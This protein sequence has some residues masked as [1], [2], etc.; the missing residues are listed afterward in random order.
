MVETNINAIKYIHSVHEFVNEIKLLDKALEYS[1]HSSESSDFKKGRLFFRGQRNAEWSVCPSVFRNDFLLEESNMYSR[2]LLSSPSDF[3]DSTTTYEKLT[4]MQHYGLPTRLLDVT[5]N[6]LIAL[7]FACEKNENTKE[8]KSIKNLISEKDKSILSPE[9][10]EIVEK[11]LI[12]NETFGEVFV[13]ADDPLEP[14]DDRVKVLA[15]LAHLCKNE[16]FNI[17]TFCMKLR[18]NMEADF[19]EEK[20]IQYLKEKPYRSVV[21]SMNNVRIKSQSGAFI[22]FG[23]LYD[24]HEVDLYSLKKVPFDIRNK[25]VNNIKKTR[26]DY[27]TDLRDGKIVLEDIFTSDLENDI[28]EYIKSEYTKLPSSE[29]YFVSESKNIEKL[30]SYVI[31]PECKG[32][33]LDELEQLGISHATV[34]PELEHQAIYIKNTTTQTYNKEIEDIDIIFDRISEKN[35]EHKKISMDIDAARASFNDRV[36]NKNTIIE[37]AVQNFV[38]DSSKAA[39]AVKSVK[40]A[41]NLFNQ[42]DW[43]NFPDKISSNKVIIKRELKRIGLDKEICEKIADLI[44]NKMIQVE[45]YK[46][47]E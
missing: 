16:N 26:N 28:F 20:L 17:S 39:L 11:A 23:L 38:D 12:E 7:Y 32:I 34:Y 9:A 2:I 19:N 29:P 40:K 45:K 42:T 46:A 24:E 44:V 30:H 47:G 31:P 35:K 25:C 13:I 43:F 14:D 33:I 21:S 37:K 6:P 18:A 27:L 22:I 4:K 36:K 8:Y 3:F 15:E 10:R 1:S 41:K 5:S